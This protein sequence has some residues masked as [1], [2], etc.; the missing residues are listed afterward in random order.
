MSNG[1]GHVYNVYLEEVFLA[2]LVIYV[3][4]KEGESRLIIRVDVLRI[5]LYKIDLVKAE[6]KIMEL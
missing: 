2:Y 4:R 3:M 1:R 5:K 6:A